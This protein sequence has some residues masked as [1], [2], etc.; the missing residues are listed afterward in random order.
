MTD[1]QSTSKSSFS[2]CVAYIGIDWG[3]EKHAV[4]VVNRNGGI[5]KTTI[6]HTPEEIAAWAE[7]VK[8]QYDGRP[9]AVGIEQSKGA[10]FYALLEFDH[11]R[12][13]PV[14]P[15]QATNYRKALYIS[16]AKSDEID[17]E[18]LAMLVRDLGDRLRPWM[19]DDPVTEKLARQC[20][21]R[22]KAVN[23]RVKLV[24]QLLSSL[25]AYFPQAAE[26]C[27]KMDTDYALNLL[28]KYPSLQAMQRAKPST[29]KTWLKRTGRASKDTLDK[30]VAK[31]RAMRPLTKNK[32]IIEPHVMQVSYLVTQIKTLNEAI[33]KFEDEINKTFTMHEDA[34]LFKG[35]PGAG[36][37]LAPRLAVAFGTDRKRFQNAA[38][39]QSL[40]GIAPVTKQS[41]NS[42]IVYR[43][44]ACPKFLLQT[45][46]EFADQ[47]R[48]WSTW[49]RAFYQSLR[50]KG[51]KH[52]AA[53]RCLAF[54][55]IRIIFRVWQTR[56]PYSESRY[57]EQLKKRQSP[58]ADLL[59]TA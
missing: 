35:L 14:N 49:S 10:M 55:W 27:G 33:K 25:K 32:S 42:K 9:V 15:A 6:A 39:L 3:D 36:K 37:A 29:L 30:L 34:S 26:I 52:N 20:E 5:H 41:G 47:A 19:A 56:E 21:F 8:A 24:Q 58:I 4:C 13:Y 18:C 50:Q 16:G 46:H 43:R 1:R 54:K 44:W 2:D 48:R 23:S 17:A 40:S 59:K 12:L 53:V 28:S 45:F 57:I 7:K 11:L 51:T 22:R 31:I 38:E